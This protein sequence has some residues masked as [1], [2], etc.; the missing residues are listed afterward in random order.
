[1]ATTPDSATSSL[2]RLTSLLDQLA[3][4]V[5]LNQVSA[6]NLASWT[7]ALEDIAVAA[8]AA[9]Y[10][11]A[12]EEARRLRLTLEA[13]PP[14]TEETA[15]AVQD[16]VKRLQ[17]LMAALPV[18]AGPPVAEVPVPPTQSA[19]PPPPAAEFAALSD[20]PELVA[21][22]ISESREHLQAIE[23]NVL[24][25]EQ[26]P[27]CTDAIHATFRAFHTI[28]GLAGFL[29][30]PGIREVAHETETLLDMARNGTLLL[31]PAVIDVIL[32]SADYLEREVRRIDDARQSERPAP[33]ADNSA[34]LAHVKVFLHDGQEEKDPQL[35]A[36]ADAVQKPDAAVP[37]TPEKAAAPPAAPSAPP[38]APKAP[39]KAARTS[40]A[41]P[42]PAAPPAPPAPAAEP[43]A[44]PAEAAASDG[45]RSGRTVA[46]TVKVDTAKLDFLVDMVGEMVI[47]QSLVRHSP[48]MAKLQS[49]SLQR[50]LAQLSRITDEVQKTA[51]A[52]RM[53]PISFL[54]QKMARLVR[55]LCRKSGKAAELVTAGEDTEL[56][57]NIVELLADPLMHMIRNAVDHGIESPEERTATGKPATAKVEL[58]ASHQAGSIVIEIGDDGR[59]M[60]R[61]VILRKA[62]ERGVVAENAILTDNEIYN[63]IFEPGF[64]TAAQ[65]T[66]ISGRGVGMDV[67]KRHIQKLRGRTEIFTKLGGGTTFRLKLPLTLAIIDGLIV[68][69]GKHRYIV[70]IFAVKEMLRPTPGMVTTVEGKR[71]IALVRQRVLPVIRLYQRFGVEPRTQ[72]PEDSL[73]ILTESQGKEY[74]LMVDA[75][76][77]KQEVV[78][79]SLGDTLK[80]IPGIAGGAIL[81]DGRVGLILDMNA[82]LGRGVIG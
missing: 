67:V 32:E 22:F 8:T 10:A 53:V 48:D 76:L 39:A 20:D 77:G 3:L 59:G 29:E 31:A 18:P 1:M 80:D 78:I 33:E 27:G 5:V 74:C 71:E 73:L 12:A 49:A 7:G 30:F 63:L 28:K 47:A 2:T 57:R 79:K 68:G 14:E 56:D 23:R 19:P 37:A 13:L 9:D 42:A 11:P 82:L 52:M 40:P 38:P 15:A 61:E 41:A 45:A 6:G 66:D 64:S 26:D 50:N 16:G 34:V 55:D 44:E 70:P 75:L 65:V 35:T 69:V 46:S 21:D 36:L 51:M 24:A 72:D 58:R 4:D 17:N 62:R 60:N 25:I 81:G 43:A 54:F